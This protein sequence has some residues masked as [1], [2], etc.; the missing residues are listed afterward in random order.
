MWAG[1]QLYLLTVLSLCE[2]R[3]IWTAREELLLEAGE[4]T[5]FPLIIDWDIIYFFIFKDRH[6]F[7]EFQE[8]ALSF[9]STITV[10]IW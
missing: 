2:D 5:C 8:D 9:F 3:N 7:K 10:V 6:T 4:A 1:L